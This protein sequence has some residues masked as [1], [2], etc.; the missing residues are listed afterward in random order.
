M[1][2]PLNSISLKVKQ[3]VINESI[4]DWAMDQEGQIKGSSTVDLSI[5]K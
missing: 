3:R 4:H 2:E 1:A 5:L